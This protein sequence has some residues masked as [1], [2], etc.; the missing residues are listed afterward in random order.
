[1]TWAAWRQ[2]GGWVQLYLDD[3]RAL[4]AKWARF[5]A[6]GLLG[7]GMWTIGFEGRPGVANAALRGAWLAGP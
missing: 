4:T 5:R 1:M 2:N 3:P 7:T 6:L